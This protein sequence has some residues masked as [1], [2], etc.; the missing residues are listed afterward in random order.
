MASYEYVVWKG[1][2]DDG[3]YWSTFDPGARKWADQHV[4]PGSDTN[5]SP[6]LGYL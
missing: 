4:I 1:S 3:I 6:A 5:K 2:G